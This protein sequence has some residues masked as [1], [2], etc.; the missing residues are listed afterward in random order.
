MDTDGIANSKPQLVKKVC[1]DTLKGAFPQTSCSIKLDCA[2]FE[3]NALC[4]S[5]P[6]YRG[7]RN[8]AVSFHEAEGTVWVQ[9]AID[10]KP[11][12]LD[13]FAP[14]AP[15]KVA[16]IGMSASIRGPA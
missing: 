8:A 9:Y 3:L 12:L 11:N 2:A 16:H 13:A 7:I 15:A 1:F 10:R 4:V 14:A 5:H 6:V